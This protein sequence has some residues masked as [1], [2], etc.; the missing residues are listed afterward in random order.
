M[1]QVDD[2]DRQLLHMLHK[3][4]RRTYSRWRPRSDCPSRR[5]APHRRL[6]ETGVITGFTVQVDHTKLGW[7]IEAFIE[8][9]CTGGTPVGEIVRTAYKVPEVQAMFT[10]AG[11]PDALVQVRVGT[12]S[13]SAGHRRPQ[14]CGQHHRDQDADGAG[15]LDAD[16]AQQPVRPGNT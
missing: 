9:S 13:I 7:S 6:R 11:D 14:A 10:I 8:L 1:A 2:I 5:Q 3:D 12:S 16:G 4:G 15:I